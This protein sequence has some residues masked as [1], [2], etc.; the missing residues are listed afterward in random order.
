MEPEGSLPYS[1]VPAT[2]PYPE[3]T[4]SGPHD[5][6]QLPENPS[7][8][9][10]IQKHLL[11]NLIELIQLCSKLSVYLYNPSNTT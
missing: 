10:L 4:P 1:Q 8:Y 9:F 5:P 11:L 6:L 7:Y 3:L 2:C